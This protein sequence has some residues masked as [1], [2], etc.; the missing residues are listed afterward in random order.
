LRLLRDRSGE[1]AAAGVRIIGISRDSPYSHRSWSQQQWL[2]F[3]LL[4]DWSGTCVRGFGAAQNRDGLDD[5]PV[6]C[7][8]LVAPGGVI[9][10]AW[11]HADGA[12]PDVSEQLAAA[13]V[14]GQEPSG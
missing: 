14:L 12:V 6:R 1:F 7:T 5:S 8:F 9:A 10:R 11:R 4:S 2:P 3:G 13:Q